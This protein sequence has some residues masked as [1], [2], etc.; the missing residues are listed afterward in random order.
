MTLQQLILH[1]P[2]STTRVQKATSNV[3]DKEEA[4][5]GRSEAC[6]GN[7]IQHDVALKSLQQQSCSSSEATHCLSLLACLMRA[8]TLRKFEG[9]F[10]STLFLRGNR[11]CIMRPFYSLLFLTSWHSLASAFLTV[12]QTSRRLLYTSSTKLFES[13]SQSDESE[14]VSRNFITNIIE[15]DIKEKKV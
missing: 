9:R 12:Q 2:I 4:D 15:D 3:K 8:A 11:T 10:I 7:D 5:S 14:I 13:T 1:L 6:F